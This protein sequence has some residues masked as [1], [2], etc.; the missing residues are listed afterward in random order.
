MKELKKCIIAIAGKLYRYPKRIN[1]FQQN[2]LFETDQRRYYRQ[3]KYRRN[4]TIR[5]AEQKSQKILDKPNITLEWKDT[6]LLNKVREGV[7]NEEQLELNLTGV[8]M[9]KD[10]RGMPNRKV[11]GSDL[12]ERYWFK[13]FRCSL[14][15]LREQFQDWLNT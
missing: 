9:S 12:A 13:I 4:Y 15:R 8:S 11:P 2:R 1:Q 10:L 14:R 6:A 5:E 3:I 7:V